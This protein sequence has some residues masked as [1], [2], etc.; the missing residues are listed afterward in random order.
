MVSCCMQ[1]YWALSTCKGKQ[2]T[3]YLSTGYG[4]LPQILSTTVTVTQ[5]SITFHGSHYIPSL[6]GI[7]LLLEATLAALLYR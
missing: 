3:N 7:K 5:S 6:E 1:P 4:G 2:F